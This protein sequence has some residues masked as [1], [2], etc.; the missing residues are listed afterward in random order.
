MAAPAAVLNVLVTANTKGAMTGLARVNTRLAATGAQAGK[1]QSAMLGMA[2]TAA[3]VGAGLGAAGLAFG[4]KKAFDE[5]REAE[6][7]TAQTEAVLKST[8]HAANVTAR[9]I[10]NLARA[11]SNKAGIDDEAIQSAA[12]MLLTFKDIR[13]EAGAGNRIF[14]QTTRIVTDMSVAMDQG[15]KQSSIQVG[16]ALND[17]IRGLTSLGRVGVQFTEQQRKQIEALVESGQKM[18]AQKIILKELRS[19]FGGSAAAQADS[20]DKLRVAWDNLF[21]SVGK[22]IGPWIMR[23]MENMARFFRQMQNGTG[24]GGD[25]VRVLNEIVVSFRHFFRWVGNAIHNIDRFGKG[26]KRVIHLVAKLWA[27]GMSFMMRRYADLIEHTLGKLP[28]VGKKFREIADRIRGAADQVDKLGENVNRL[29]VRKTLQLRV[30]LAMEDLSGVPRLKDLSGG[31][32][33]GPPSTA[34]MMGGIMDAGKQKTRKWLVNNMDKIA[35]LLGSPGGMKGSM[36]AIQRMSMAMG[37]SGGMGPGQNFRQGDPGWHGQGR[38]TDHSGPAGA[39]MKFARTLFSRMGSRL[40]ELIYTP[41]GVGIKNGKPVNIQSFYGPAVAADHYDHVHVAMQK[42]GLVQQLSS[43]GEVAHFNKFRHLKGLPS[44]G[45]SRQRLDRWSDA[46][47]SQALEFYRWYRKHIRSQHRGTPPDTLWSQ[48][49]GGV[50]GTGSGDKVPA[51]L[52]PGEFVMNRKATAK[53]G[54]LLAALNKSIPRFASGGTVARAAHAAGFRGGDLLRAVAEAKGESGWNERAVGDGGWSKGLMQIYTKV[55]GWARGMNLFDPFVNMRAAKRIFDSQGWGA[56]HADHTPH[57]GAARAAIES[58]FG[59]KGGGGKKGTVKRA[60]RKKAG[61]TLKRMPTGW[62]FSGTWQHMAD[63]Q[64]MQQALAALTPDLA[65]DIKVA[66]DAIGWWQTLLGVAQSTGD[67][68]GITQAATSLKQWQ[69]ELTRLTE[70]QNDLLQQQIDAQNAHTNA[71]N[72]LKAEQAATRALVGAQGPALT[73][74][75]IQMINGGIGGNAGL[76]RQ[77]PSSTGLGGLSRA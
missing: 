25:F 48:R 35:P 15:L 71:V 60:P 19:E 65:D 34:D 56:W 33:G 12:N 36:G 1:T 31:P 41:M 10:E 63:Q 5:F 47:P 8:G 38:A 50:P 69:D 55:H 26:M 11:I 18:K 42:G 21:E 20:A 6:K 54:P 16:K 74:A 32:S 57:I 17:P 44:V 73:S 2:K 28:I 75:L 14:D 9:E 46:H 59:G 22:A 72:E 3:K 67:V 76:G 27:D 37:L 58:A 61:D 4:V 24:A 53:A 40:L 30:K 43:G 77:F 51:L 29:P 23:A 39:M 66:Q 70:D 62:D 45:W 64:G 68:G 49:G 13:N 7:A 52:E